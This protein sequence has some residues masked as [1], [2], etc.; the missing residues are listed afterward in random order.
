[1]ILAGNEERFFDVNTLEYFKA[2]KPQEE[3]AEK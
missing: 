3:L 1:M 2:D